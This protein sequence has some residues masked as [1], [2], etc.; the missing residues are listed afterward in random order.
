MY[1]FFVTSMLFSLRPA[2]FVKSSAASS[3]SGERRAIGRSWYPQPSPC[4]MK[5]D[6]PLAGDERDKTLF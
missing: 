2:G 5:L 3:E 4:R 6:G 1:F